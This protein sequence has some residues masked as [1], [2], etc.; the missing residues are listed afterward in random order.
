MDFENVCENTIKAAGSRQLD[1]WVVDERLR[2]E[3]CIFPL[4]REPRLYRH[5]DNRK[6]PYYSTTWCSA[7]PLYD[8]LVTLDDP[9]F[10]SC[11]LDSYEKEEQIFHKFS[12]AYRDW[13]KMGREKN[14]RVDEQE[15]P[16]IAITRGWLIA[17]K[18][19]LFEEG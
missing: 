4:G 7:G 16:A 2:L 12:C 19:G 9:S 1:I 8:E 15:S 17:C 6:I 13:D 3:K 11:L 10:D 18:R 14:I 5:I